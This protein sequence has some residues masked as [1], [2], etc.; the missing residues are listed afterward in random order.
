MSII[1]IPA[2]FTL[3]AAACAPL[4][5]VFAPSRGSCA[6][7]ALAAGGMALHVVWLDDAGGRIA[8]RYRRSADAG[9]MW[10][11]PVDLTPEPWRRS[12]PPSIA[13]SRGM[14]HVVWC[15]TGQ[16]P[17]GEIVHLRSV[18][19]GM[20]WEQPRVLELEAGGAGFVSVA[21]WSRSVHVAWVDRVGRLH[22]M[23]SGD[24]GLTWRPAMVIGRRQQEHD[25]AAAPRV[26]ADGEVTYLWTD[27]RQD[28]PGMRAWLGVVPVF[29]GR[30]ATV[31]A[32]DARS[33]VDGGVRWDAGAPL[34]K[35]AVDRAAPVEFRYPILLSER[36]RRVLV[37]AERSGAD[38]GRM[39]WMISENGGRTWAAEGGIPAGGAPR[40]PSAVLRDGIL[41]AVW[42]AVRGSSA[43]LRTLRLGCRDNEYEIAEIAAGGP[44]TVDPSLAVTDDGTVHV[45]ACEERD[46]FGTLRYFR[47]VMERT[48]E[49]HRE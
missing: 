30:I 20:S 32:I 42:S 9:K 47:S 1:C 37:W 11:A 22:F 49:E 39:R 3:A 13:V 36:R 35:Q 46:G 15:E 14:V 10:E 26:H 33:S 41:Y 16:N 18:D 27:V 28:Y 2:A 25:C 40:R 4:Y 5:A 23:G 8:V 7:P 21:T 43:T 17:A 19:G 6:A 34:V 12:F 24:D 31:T 29:T 38:S 45:T 48:W 44:R